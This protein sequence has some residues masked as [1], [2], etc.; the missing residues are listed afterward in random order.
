M[1]QRLQS[2]D[3]GSPIKRDQ[4]YCMIASVGAP[5]DQVSS[6]SAATWLKDA[7]VT[8]KGVY[9]F[10]KDVYGNARV[11][12]AEIDAVIRFGG[13]PVPATPATIDP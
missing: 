12:G 1:M 13:T 9:D 2:R 10:D 4:M 11:A 6:A 7:R 8:W 5:L 3:Y